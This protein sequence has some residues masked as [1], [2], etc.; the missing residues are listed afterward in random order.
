MLTLIEFFDDNTHKCYPFADVNELPTDFLVD[1][2]ILI[3]DNVQ[4][5]SVYISSVVIT[6]HMVQL[7]IDAN[8]KQH[9]R[10]SL[11]LLASIPISSERNKEYAVK[12][13]N[14]K[15]QVIIEGSITVGSFETLLDRRAGVYELEGNK[16]KLFSAC[17]IPVT[18]W[19]T[20]LIINNKLY[21]GLVSIE[22]SAGFNITAQDKGGVH[23][24]VI[25]AEEFAPP[26]DINDI[27]VTDEEIEARAAAL[28]DKGVTSING[29]KGE[30]TITA[31]STSSIGRTYTSN[32][33]GNTLTDANNLQVNTTD[34]AIIINNTKDDP[35]FDINAAGGS[36]NSAAIAT[37]LANAKALNDRA[38]VIDQHN[39]AVDN[40]VNLLSTQVAKVN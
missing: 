25:D 4:S 8:M 6:E 1:A 5:K 9:G 15:Y 13:I 2:H 30:I 37:L 21:T 31:D 36:D 3:T 22:F 35:N 17:V 19:C 34:Q 24:L 28:L 27:T 23:R 18:E 12:L 38:A 20:G 26:K 14:D 16:G 7:Y 10:V 39:Y 32:T 33:T 40:A 11:G 29:A